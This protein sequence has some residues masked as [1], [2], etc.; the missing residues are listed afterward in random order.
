VGVRERHERER[1]EADYSSIIE[2]HASMVLFSSHPK[3]LYPITSDV[4]T[5]TWNINYILKK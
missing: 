4:W 3:T 2:T 5:H 1:S